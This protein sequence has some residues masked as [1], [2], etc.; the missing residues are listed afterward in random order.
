[1]EVA[2]DLLQDFGSARR[3]GEMVENCRMFSEA[4]FTLLP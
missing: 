2:T 1:M 4:D 3:L